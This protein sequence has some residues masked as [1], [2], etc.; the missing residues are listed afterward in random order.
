MVLCIPILIALFLTLILLFY[1]I[2]NTDFCPNCKY[3]Q[4]IPWTSNFCDD[5]LY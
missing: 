3:V 4:C 5:V 2:Q 1:E